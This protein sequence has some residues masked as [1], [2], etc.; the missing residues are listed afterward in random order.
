MLDRILDLARHLSAQGTMSAA[1][2][3]DTEHHVAQLQR[4]L[5]PALDLT[6]RGDGLRS[7]PLEPSRGSGGHSDSTG[8]LATADWGFT[9]KQRRGAAGKLDQAADH[10]RT[11]HLNLTNATQGLDP[12]G[13]IGDAVLGL[14]D[15]RS[16]VESTLPLPS[17]K[18]RLDP[19]QGTPACTSCA[20]I[21]NYSAARTGSTY[22]DWCARWKTA[23]GKPPLV[24]ILHIHAAGRRLT[25]RA[26][27]EA[28]KAEAR[29]RTKRRK[30]T[31]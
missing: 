15:A 29:A 16:L 22:C 19:N 2:H 14:A 25:T 24:A 3:A 1:D 13:N 23:H 31:R 26:V 27:H 4:W 7:P 12:I 6:T 28:E 8:D 10:I 9:G 11:A 20:R 18:R 5:Q 21:E 30:A 17:A